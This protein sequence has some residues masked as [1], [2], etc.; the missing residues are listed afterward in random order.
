LK[1][2]HRPFENLHQVSEIDHRTKSGRGAAAH[3]ARA[4]SRM[5]TFGADRGRSARLAQQMGHRN[6]GQIGD[7]ARAYLATRTAVKR[8]EK[9]FLEELA[10]FSYSEE[11]ERRTRPADYQA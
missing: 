5:A 11:A 8:P 7:I 2:I 9:V 4:G 6:D 10:G 3:K 1:E